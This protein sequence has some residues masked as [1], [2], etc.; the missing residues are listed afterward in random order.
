M[1]PSLIIAGGYTAGHITPGIALAEALTPDVDCIFM[2]ARD[3]MEA[4]LIAQ[5]GLPFIGVPALPWAGRRAAARAVSLATLMPA[6][7][8]ARRAIK[9]SRA[10][11]LVS[12]GSFAALAPGLAAV[13]LGLPV[14]LYESNTTLG[15]AN[16][17]LLP[18]AKALL[19]SRL[20]HQSLHR[21]PHPDVVGV[22][23]RHA[24]QALATQ[25]VTFPA[26]TVRVLVL[27][28]SLGNPFLNQ[29]MPAVMHLLA[30]SHPGLSIIHQAG[31]AIAPG[32]IARSYA[33]LEVDASV[34]SYLDPIAPAFSSAH[35]IVATAGAITLHE[36][37]AAGVPALIVPL[38]GAAARHQHDNAFAFTSLTGCPHVSEATW[39]DERVAATLAGLLAQPGAWLACSERLRSLVASPAAVHAATLVRRWL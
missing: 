19:T 34:H 38:E 9:Q 36:L 35:L 16:R 7:L 31:H 27:G 21:G 14:I 17:V 33:S 37:A 20:F 32:T 12:L 11:A 29:R 25:Q 18:F 8:T 1:R 6:I 22:P 23:L 26:G 10:T 3:G 13:S 24:V 4:S 15:L 28:G 2:G 5:A 30:R 39:A